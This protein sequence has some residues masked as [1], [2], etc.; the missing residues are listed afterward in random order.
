MKIENTELTNTWLSSAAKFMLEA[1]TLLNQ[2][3]RLKAAEEMNRA[4]NRLTNGV[5]IEFNLLP[6]EIKFKKYHIP[7]RKKALMP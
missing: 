6:E 3:N 5:E 1:Q 7:D 2:G 4:A